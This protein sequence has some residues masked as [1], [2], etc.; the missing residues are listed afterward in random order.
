MS[1]KQDL[2]ERAGS[3]GVDYPKSATKAE[4][5]DLILAAHPDDELALAERDDTPP[6]GD[7]TPPAGDAGDDAGQAEA[8]QRADVETE[9]GYSG[10]KVDPFPNEAYS[11]E[12]DPTTSPG[13]LESRVALDTLA[14][15]GTDRQAV[16]AAEQAAEEGAA[17]QNPDE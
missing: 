16:N 8:Q 1:T 11:Q 5:V 15:G 2:Q 9:Q 13:V 7:D 4:L 3:L 17:R 14:G 10:E 6:A 12:S